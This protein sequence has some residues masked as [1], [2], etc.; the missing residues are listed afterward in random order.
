M[1]RV[2]IIGAGELGT[3]L[4]RVLDGKAEVAL[5]DVDAAKVPGMKPLREVVSDA[6]V[7]LCAVPSFAM[8]SA[9]TGFLPFIDA[10]KTVII[11]LAKGIEAKTRRF[12]DEVLQELIPGD[13]WAVMGGP[14]LAAELGTGKE[15]AAVLAF[16]LR[17]EASEGAAHNS[18]SGG[19]GNLT[20]IFDGTNLRV[21]VSDDV[22]GVAVAGVL[23]NVYAVLMGVAAGLNLGEDE[24]A[25]L[26]SRAMEEMD[27]IGVKLGARAETIRGTAGFADFLA[28]A[29]SNHSRNR[30][31]GIALAV[32]GGPSIKGEGI[33]SLSPL[34]ELLGAD[35]ASFPLLSALATIVIKN[36]NP[37]KTIQ[38]LFS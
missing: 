9:I 11:S 21:E 2:A 31:T 7:I 36:Q 5:W 14:M 37:R 23:K 25:W 27:A 10:R 24:T 1:K 8:R 28:T 26:A 35:S 32:D 19:F 12:M 15:C 6:D 34:L 30:N 13:R 29:Y 3:A 4:A 22:H 18:E 33:L 17:S 20:S 38:T 16:L